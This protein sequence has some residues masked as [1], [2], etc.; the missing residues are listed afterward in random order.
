MQLLSISAIHRGAD[1]VLIIPRDGFL[2][3]RR[4][5]HL[6][7]IC[8]KL[9]D[10]DSEGLDVFDLGFRS[11]RGDSGVGISAATSG[12][13]GALSVIYLNLTRFRGS[14][15]AITMRERADE[16]NR[17]TQAVQFQLLERIARLRSEGEPNDSQ[18]SLF[19]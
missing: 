1:E 8:Q 14:D 12:A 9:R 17:A 18:S 7:R 11:A 10:G 15:W 4:L 13:V 5:N 3:L 16:L 2:R 6:Q 19:Q